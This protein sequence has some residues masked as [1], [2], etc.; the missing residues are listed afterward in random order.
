MHTSININEFS[1][2]EAHYNHDTTTPKAIVL[3]GDGA[4]AQNVSQRPLAYIF[5]GRYY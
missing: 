5:Q 1:L 3:K 2:Q 4:Q